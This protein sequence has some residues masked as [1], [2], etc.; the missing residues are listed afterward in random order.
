MSV[1]LL[2][3]LAQKRTIVRSADRLVYFERDS[4]D[5]NSYADLLQ[6][7]GA[8]SF[9]KVILFHFKGSRR[10]RDGRGWANVI[11]A[12]TKG[13][14]ATPLWCCCRAV[15]AHTYPRCLWYL[16]LPIRGGS[17]TFLQP[18]WND[19]QCWQ[20]REHLPREQ[21]A[22]VSLLAPVRA[23]PNLSGDVGTQRPWVSFATAWLL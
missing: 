11:I 18:C 2:I 9:R 14:F 17:K 8:L 1:P 4:I 12:S 13:L 6:G 5:N 3:I 15:R 16:G 23:G 21:L 7:R 20:W 19:Q 10:W 22:L